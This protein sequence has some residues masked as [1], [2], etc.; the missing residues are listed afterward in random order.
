MHESNGTLTEKQSASHRLSANTNNGI[1]KEKKCNMPPLSKIM[2]PLSEMLGHKEVENHQDWVQATEAMTRAEI[3][4]AVGELNDKTKGA[5][6][7][8]LLDYLAD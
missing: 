4:E 3:A 6:Y 5:L 8:A 7:E 1:Y 2:P